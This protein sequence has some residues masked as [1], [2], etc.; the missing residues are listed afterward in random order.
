MK[1][2]RATS[3]RPAPRKAS[4]APRPVTG[5]TARRATRAPQRGLG[6]LMR[7]D[8]SSLLAATAPRAAAKT[9][10]DF[11]QLVADSCRQLARLQRP[12][13]HAQGSDA[14]ADSGPS[15]HPTNSVAMQKLS[16]RLHQT[17]T[18]LLQGDS[19]KQVALHLGLSRHT[20]HAYV[21]GLY[22]HF[23][24]NSRGELLARFVAGGANT[25]V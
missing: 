3:K 19:E 13:R 6:P 12:P 2:E 21:K 23:G 8:L 22:R 11:R 25:S 9:P 14:A 20:I 17:L 5:T 10:Q 7:I 16:R 4:P 15:Y 1:T 18:A 24:V